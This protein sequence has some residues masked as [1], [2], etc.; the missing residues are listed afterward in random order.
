VPADHRQEY[1]LCAAAAARLRDAGF[2]DAVCAV[3]TG[4][5][6]R[7]PDLTQRRTL[8]WADIPGFPKPT[9]PGHRGAIH[10]G[11]CRGSPTIVLEGRTHLYEGH[12][13]ADV[14]RAVRTVGLLGVKNVVLTNAA[15]GVREDLRA[16]DVVRIVDHVSFLPDPLVGIHEPRFGDRFVIAAGRSYDATL[17]RFADEAAVEAGVTLYS[18]VYA[19][20]TGPTFETPAEVRMLR[21]LGADVSGMS[22]IPEVLAAT[23]LGMRVLALSFVANPAGVV[24]ADSTAEAEVLAVGASLGD[25]VARIVEGIVARIAAERR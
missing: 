25:S 23:Q 21:T 17:A 15:G 1:E 13:P 9:A 19:A 6:L 20:K 8:A 4:S 22:T 10:H 5:G 16:G 7:P 3:Q 18:G 14:I 12:A 11:L 2:A 24:A